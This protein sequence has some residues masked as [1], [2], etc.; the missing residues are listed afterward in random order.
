MKAV[1]NAQLGI[2]HKLYKELNIEGDTKD[3]MLYLASNGKGTSSKDLSSWQADVLIAK[4]SK[5]AN[6]GRDKMRKS[7]LHYFHN[8]QWYAAPD[9]LDY[10]RIDNWLLK[11]GKFGKKLNH[12]TKKELQKTV[13]QVKIMY[14][15]SL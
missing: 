8:L 3:E 13:T 11:Y 10:D 9:V 15:K 1:T 7:I 6:D 5:D 2:L 14:N 12:L 4:L